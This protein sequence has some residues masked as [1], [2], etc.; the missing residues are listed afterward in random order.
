MALAWSADFETGIDRIDSQHQGLVGLINELGTMLAAG[1][2][3][4]ADATASLYDRLQAYVGDHFRAE[5][6]LMREHDLDRRHVAPHL[7]EHGRF[8]QQLNGLRRVLADS[9]GAVVSAQL[10]G[11]LVH[12]L[13]VHVLDLDQRMA[14]QIRLI[15]LG[16][17]PALA[18]EESIDLTGRGGA[19][20]GAALS[21]VMV[22]VYDALKERKQTAD[23]LRRLSEQDPL[24]GLPNRSYFLAA[25]GQAIDQARDSGSAL[26]LLLIDVDDLGTL[27][28]TVG[29]ST[30][31]QLLVALAARLQERSRQ[32][33]LVARIGNDEFALALTGNDA[34]EVLIE[35]AKRLFSGLLAPVAG[36][37]EALDFSLS[38]GLAA[39]P[40]HAQ[41]A[42]PLLAAAEVALIE[43]K[44]EGGGS[45]RRF[46]PAMGQPGF[47]R[48]AAVT[49]LRRAIQQ[50]ELVLHYQP[51][52]SLHS[53]EILGLEALVRWQHPERGLVP[54]GQFI[55]LAEESGLIVGLG[56]WVIHEG[57]SQL[58]RWRDQNL[59]LVRLAVN[60]SAHHFR[61]PGLFDYVQHLLHELDVSANL[62][63][64]ELTESVMMHDPAA[65]IRLVNDFHETGVRFSLDDYGTGFSSLSYL[66]RFAIDTLKIDQSFVRDI[67]TN[68]VNSSIAVATIAMAH[69]LGKTVIAE[70]VE[71]AGQM[72]FLRR[73][74]C[75]EMQGYYFSRPVPA[76]G[77][78]Q[79]LREGHCLNLGHADEAELPGLLLVDDEP[80]VLNALRRLLR[81]EG[82]RI[83]TAEN[84]AQAFGLLAA[85]PV[86]V[87]V[88]DQRMP[89]MTGSEFLARVKMMYPSTVR[90]VL[91]GYSEFNAVTD[92]INR[93]AIYRFL[94]KPWRDE[95]LKQAIRE[96]FRHFR[97][98]SG[99][100]ASPG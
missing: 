38:G 96:A 76:D 72:A 3:M 16:R 48:A 2:D 11:F 17:P 88:S 24:T 70:G 49:A 19:I 46:E 31:D 82:Y 83:L 56:E 52:V 45:C 26:V 80:N 63:E 95:D 77:V 10:M 89:E 37:G 9:P 20:S 71:T 58:R 35:T 51:Q 18:Y 5:E 15:G 73:S 13:G 92:S 67:T 86:Q 53:G 43:A 14:R 47:L 28:R 60:V 29:H 50:G 64:I 41:E 8:S 22:D 94:S 66:S 4:G 100:G 44:H 81:R 84:A 87:I 1:E 90:I 39:M 99:A 69:K 62:F 55:P 40:T 27:N 97:E 74:D 7:A 34:V 93:G 59:P 42:G 57:L 85:N 12:W 32:L 33:D 65:A 78:A 36:A 21:Q 79:M 25:L 75:D 98:R 54:P 61:Q 91:S 68:P 6:V 30:A 23:S